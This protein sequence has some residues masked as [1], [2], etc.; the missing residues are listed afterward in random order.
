[1]LRQLQFRPDDNK[2]ELQW[3]PFITKHM[4]PSSERLQQYYS[5][6]QQEPFKRN[7]AF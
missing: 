4:Q 6:K 3:L 5:H 2:G 7:A 1:M